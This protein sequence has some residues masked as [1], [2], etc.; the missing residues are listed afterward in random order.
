[1]QN[2]MLQ[3][4]F[5]KR[6]TQQK[7]ALSGRA[8]KN[9][10]ID[11][12]FS[13][14]SVQIHH[15]LTLFSR[16]HITDNDTVAVIL[17][18]GIENALLCISLMSH[19]TLLPINPQLSAEELVD[20]FQRLSV[21]VV[22]S[23]PACNNNVAKAIKQTEIR[24]L[25]VTT[26]DNLT[27]QALINFAE[28]PQSYHQKKQLTNRSASLI[29]M[30]SGSTST[31]KLVPLSEDNL[32][33]S[34]QNLNES[35]L[36]SEKDCCFNMLPLYH[37]G[38]LL[39]MLLA[40]LLSG[41][42]VI[43]ATDMQAS[44]LKE[45]SENYSLTWIQAVPTMLRQ[46]VSELEASGVKN[47][48]SLRFIRSVSAPLSETLQSRAEQL[49]QVPVVEIYGMTEATGL[50]TS[51]PIDISLR[52]IASVG[53]VEQTQVIITDDK[54]TILSPENIGQIAIRGSNLMEGY[55]YIDNSEYFSVINGE[56]FFLTGDEGYLDQ[57][58]FL[59]LTGRLKDVINRG[60]EKISPQEIDNCLMQHKWVAQVA[61]FSLPHISL[62]ED[63]AVAIVLNTSVKD[64]RTEVIKILKKY[65]SSQI[66][67]F[68]IPRTWF[69][70]ENLPYTSGGKLQRYKLSEQYAEQIKLL[71]L[72]NVATQEKPKN[73]EEQLICRIWQKILEVKNISP[74]DNF[75]D[76]GGDSLKA[77]AFII[78][79]EANLQIKNETLI[80]NLYDYPTVREFAACLK[81]QMAEVA[82]NRNDNAHLS[83]M[84]ETDII[85]DDVKSMLSR[86]L[87][88]WQGERMFP[89]SLIIGQNTSGNKPPIFWCTQSS[90]EFSR[91]CACFDE[92]QP[93]YGFRS[94]MAIRERGKRDYPSLAAYYIQELLSIYP[95]GRIILGGFCEGSCVVFEMAKQ[96]VGT[97]I[98]VILLCLQDRIIN[99][100]AELLVNSKIVVFWSRNKY[101]HLPDKIIYYGG[102]SQPSWGVKQLYQNDYS[103]YECAYSHNE[104]YQFPTIK[105]WVNHLTAE[106]TKQ[107]EK[108]KP[109]SPKLKTLTE[110]VT[111]EAYFC[112]KIDFSAPRL[113]KPN[114][115][116]P[117]TI[118][119]TNTSP[120]TWQETTQSGVS[121]C[122]RWLNHKGEAKEI[123][124]HHLFD[125][126]V[127]VRQTLCLSLPV[128]VPN[129]S[130]KLYQL[131]V[132][133]VQ[134]GISWLSDINDNRVSR[135]VAIVDF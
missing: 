124:N 83:F 15:C 30:T 129:L 54:Q 36:L 32:L 134:E 107:L 100:S 96:L 23:H 24:S 69:F 39:D 47:F 112:Y 131:E 6:K 58:G 132:G 118:K 102:F 63:I 20:I 13:D 2:T 122:V 9:I 66:A 126:P 89:N 99:Q 98:E 16:H 76:L 55:L 40:P 110:I 87:S 38:G 123:A 25:N 10:W 127:S 26:S 68:K 44:S 133:L 93:I 75:F 119:I 57:N 61:C 19:A 80:A 125:S 45:S 114:R 81:E 108:S 31:P 92:N 42:H 106:I 135:Y 18:Q 78:Q 67:G 11:L 74:T 35:L 59:Y 1:M 27:N 64:N 101:K 21:D 103:F 116:I 79:L 86:Y 85:S 51:N 7:L 8:I 12:T 130:F 60:G 113:V 5:E 73:E 65:L 82:E 34:C 117:L 3:Q 37:I 70:T 120:S 49:F 97:Q 104:M 48:H 88:A 41:G 14:L 77:V 56:K 72:E 62:G 17:P 50:I 4:I 90:E 28:K 84:T 91:F 115:I 95:N 52:K 71:P 46:I 109:I 22:I 94:L 53:K 111:P 33:S 121:L 128:L 105:D 43:V 29:L